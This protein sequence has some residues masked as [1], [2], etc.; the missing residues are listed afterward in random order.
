MKTIE[1]CTP[2]FV[3]RLQE[4]NMTCSCASCNERSP[5]VERSWKNQKRYSARLGCDSAA[6]AIL[7]PSDA[8]VLYP[9]ESEAC[10]APL[11][12]EPVLMLN[13]GC[14][15]L[16]IGSD[17]PLELRL[18]AMGIL[19]S[20]AAMLNDAA[21]V[22]AITQDLL[23][24]LNEGVLADAFNQIP[25]IPALKIQALRQLCDLDLRGDFDP[26]MAMALMLKI[27]E[28]SV[29]GNDD[30][31]HMLQEWQSSQAVQQALSLHLPQW[32][33]LV[34][35]SCYHDVFPGE[36]P[37]AWEKSFYQLTLRLFHVQHLLALLVQ[38][39]VNP[40]EQQL[41]HLIAARVRA[42]T[43]VPS[44]AEPLLAGLALIR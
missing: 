21:T 16:L 11:L 22:D 7:V 25:V 23:D 17:Q 39:E 3:L 43:T 27:N 4:N 26:Q 18:Y 2:E 44:Q 35:H 8:F 42:E 34:L 10:D 6:E 36:E 41:A 5:L 13:Q 28:I 9:G 30:L 24:L 19:I 14:I 29:L 32:I 33:N 12:S 20:K 38:C 37:A 40:N 15:N 31:H 1:S